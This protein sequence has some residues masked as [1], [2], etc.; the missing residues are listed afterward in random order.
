MIRATIGM[1]DGP[2]G[3]PL[4]K[5]T[6]MFDGELRANRGPKEKWEIR[7]QFHPQLKDLWQIHPS[8]QSA[9]R[10]RYLPIHGHWIIDQHHSQNLPSYPKPDNA[11]DLL[12]PLTVG[13]RVFHPL[14]RNSLAL[15]CSLKII[16]L[17]KETPGHVYQGGDL[18]NR[19]KTLFDALSTPNMDQVIQDST[20]TDPIYCLLEDDHL[21]TRIDVDTQRL[22]GRSQVSEHEVHLLM[23]VDVCVVDARAYNQCFLGD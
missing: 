7:K 18:D 17:R 3:L 4:M 1:G 12:E 21:I 22:L 5:F 9:K 16:F 13:G 10:N 14:V 2:Y 15:Q 20:I 23:E 19:I 6:L 8:L 11:I